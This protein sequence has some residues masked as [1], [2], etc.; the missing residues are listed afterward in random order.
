MLRQLA[1]ATLFIA[2]AHADARARTPSLRFDFL[3]PGKVCSATIFRDGEGATYENAAQHN[4]V[5]WKRQLRMG[6]ALSLRLAP[7]GG[8][9]I[10]IAAGR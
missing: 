9:A 8:A 1:A 4:I 3:D 6:D 10:R 5:T 7:G 2:A